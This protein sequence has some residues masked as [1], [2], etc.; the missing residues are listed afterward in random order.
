MNYFKIIKAIKPKKRLGQNFLINPHIAE[1]EAEFG[2]GKIVL[3]IGPGL[4]MLTRALLSHAV[5][6]IA[7][8]KDRE[9]YTLLKHEFRE[10]EKNLLLI[11]KDILDIKTDDIEAVD[12]II[13]NVPYN[14]SSK[15]LDLIANLKIDAVLCLQKEF[16]E[17]MLAR[18][19]TKKYSKLSVFS[20]LQFDVK[21][22]KKINSNNFYPVP[23]VDS[24]IIYIKSKT[25]IERE[26]LNIISFIMMHK[27]KTLRNS[28]LDSS[29]KLGL[30][31]ESAESFAVQN[32]YSGEKV[33]KLSPVQLL[34]IAKMIKKLQDSA[35]RI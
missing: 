21:M 22:L 20:Q 6:V 32:I 17:H 12:I 1:F 19:G 5:K 34:E 25:E 11:N 26:I 7:V 3:E 16:V 27:K 4:G 2:T 23:K 35:K 31:K 18:H 15:V 8:E 10:N 30:S 9:M 28:I 24:S 33:F 14:I 29:K 13:A